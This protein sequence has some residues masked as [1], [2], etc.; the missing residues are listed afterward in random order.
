MTKREVVTD[1]IA[2]LAG[3]IPVVFTA[4]A[5]G[6]DFDRGPTGCLTAAMAFLTGGF[7]ILLKRAMP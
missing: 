1:L 3:A 6:Y 5:G 2:F 4:W 7:A